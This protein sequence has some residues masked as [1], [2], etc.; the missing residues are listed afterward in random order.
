M[1]AALI[2]RDHC[3]AVVAYRASSEAEAL[4]WGNITAQFKGRPLLGRE[5]A[6]RFP[7][8]LFDLGGFALRDSNWQPVDAGDVLRREP[9]VIYSGEHARAPVAAGGV[10]RVEWIG[11]SGAEGIYRLRPPQ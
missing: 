4:Q 11:F 2:D 7:R 9:C 3:L 8:T 5:I 1:A 6:E 10:V